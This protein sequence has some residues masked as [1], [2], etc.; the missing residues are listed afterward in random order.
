MKD[1]QNRCQKVVELE[2]L[3]DETTEKYESELRK[4]NIKTYQKKL[5]L[6]ERNLE[7]LTK[8]HKHQVELNSTL[9]RNLAIAEK[10]I[11]NRNER[12]ADLER[13]FMDLTKKMQTEQLEYLN[14]SSRILIC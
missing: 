4:S 7:Q 8:S 9:Q 11:L 14:S 3:L 10:K 2:I 12:I 6:L 5:S 13:V 1:L